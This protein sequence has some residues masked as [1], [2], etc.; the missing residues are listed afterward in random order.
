MESISIKLG[1]LLEKIKKLETDNKK[2]RDKLCEL[3]Y[4]VY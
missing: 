4:I 3:G 2:L 1:E